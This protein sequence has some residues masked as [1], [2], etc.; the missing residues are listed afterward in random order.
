MTVVFDLGNRDTPH[1]SWTSTLTGK[2]SHFGLEP[3]RSSIFSFSFQRLPL[4]WKLPKVWRFSLHVKKN[5][6]YFPDNFSGFK[7]FYWPK[8]ETKTMHKKSE[9]DI[10]VCYTINR[11][12][13]RSCRCRRSTVH[14]VI[15]FSKTLFVWSFLYKQCTSSLLFSS[16]C[17]VCTKN[18]RHVYEL[19]VGPQNLKLCLIL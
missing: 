4:T 14:S 3:R 12:D 8:S 5:S 17:I 2:L 11:A 7:G 10:S 9:S 13:I 15:F 19:P 18:S 16:L 1:G 6:W